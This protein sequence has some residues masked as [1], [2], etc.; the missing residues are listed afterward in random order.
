MFLSRVSD[1]L[2][3]ALAEGAGSGSRPFNRSDR[4]ASVQATGPPAVQQLGENW[5]LHSSDSL[6]ALRSVVE[7]CK[8]IRSCGLAECEA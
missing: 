3:K 5:T 8:I 2:I 4:P 7:I 6:Y 1:R